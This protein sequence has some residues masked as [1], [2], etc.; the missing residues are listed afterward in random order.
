MPF[1][2]T[3]AKVI[4]HIK[5]SN[6][7]DQVEVIQFALRLARTRPLTSQELGTLADRLAEATD[8]AEIR[9]LKSAMTRGF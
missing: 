2:V 6:P 4:E 1:S 7:G 8:P 3:A 9:R 5:G